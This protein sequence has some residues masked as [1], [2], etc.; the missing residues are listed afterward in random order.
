MSSILEVLANEPTS[1]SY[2]V[3]NAPLLPKEGITEALEDVL[4]VLIG[5]DIIRT[6]EE[7]EQLKVNQMCIDR[8]RG[9][10]RCD[11]GQFGQGLSSTRFPIGSQRNEPEFG[12]IPF[13]IC[14]V[15][16]S[17]E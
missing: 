14:G 9:G 11:V 13:C 4:V 17:L 3:N 7:I 12:G 6:D 5:S 8:R 16:D 2:S 15:H 10:Q 1:K